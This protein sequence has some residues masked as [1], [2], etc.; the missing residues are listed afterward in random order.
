MKAVKRAGT[1]PELIMRSALRALRVRFRSQRNP[2]SSVAR[3]ADFV[4]L[5]FHVVVFVDG[6]FWHGCPRHMT[7]PRANGAW[8]RE[9]ISG[10]RRRDRKTARLLRAA[11]WSVIRMW[12]H[13]TELPMRNLESAISRRLQGPHAR[14]RLKPDPEIRARP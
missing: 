1:G 2:V 13:D 14:R 11:G 4:L 10:N 8:W 12:E 9:K 3:R 7:W 5:D 6:C